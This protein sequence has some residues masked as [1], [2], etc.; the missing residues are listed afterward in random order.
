MALITDPD[1]LSGTEVVITTAD[2]KIQ[3][4]IAGNLSTD[5][6]TL[7]CLYSYLKEEW[8][9]DSNLIKYPFPMQAI[10]E[11]KFELINSWDFKDSTTRELIRTGGWALKDDA[12]VSLEEYSCIISLGSI[13]ATDQVYYQQSVGGSATNI[14]LTGVVNQA[15][16]VY[17]D[18]THGNFNYRTYFKIFVRTQAKSYSSASLSDIGVT[19]MTYQTY[20][21]PLANASDLK[22]THV[23]SQ[24]IGQSPYFGTSVGSG[25][26]GTV[27]GSTSGFTSSSAF[28]FGDVGRFICIPSSASTNTGFYQITQ[29]IDADNVMVDRN[30][31]YTETNI[32]FSIN[33]PGIYIKWYDVAQAR[34]IGSTSYDFHVIIEGNNATAEQIYEFVQYQLRQNNDIDLSGGTEIGVVTSELLRFVGD[35]LYTLVQNGGTEGVFVDNFQTNDT[36]R[37]IFADDTGTNRTFPYVASLTLTFGENLTNDNSGKYWV[38]F[39]ND[40]AATAPEGKDYGTSG[41]TLLQDKDSYVM[42]GTTTGITNIV[43]TYDYDG[44]VQRGSGSEAKD[45]PITVVAIGLGTAQFVKATG[46]ITRSTSNS[47]SLVAAL[48]RNYSNI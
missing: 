31:A 23:D 17:G 37:L 29:Y 15:I 5:G 14:V 4:V 27:T 3:L 30:F 10:T 33:D 42:S 1:L 25:T 48:E 44:N 20:R 19:T 8:K 13:G 36:N 11:E 43:H 34:T 46:T 41:A 35:T 47:V 24:I 2:R 21:F 18:V 38:F 45:V 32:T 26:D 22:I 9:N 40:Q 6:V 39:T 28:E 12:G 16:K 7:Q